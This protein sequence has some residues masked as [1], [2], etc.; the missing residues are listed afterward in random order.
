MLSQLAAVAPSIG[1][2][3]MLLYTRERASCQRHFIFLQTILLIT[4]RRKRM[5]F[6]R[7]FDSLVI[8]NLARFTT[9]S[10]A[11]SD[12]HRSMTHSSEYPMNSS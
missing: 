6:I 2:S 11:Q 1:Q 5:L 4:E 9:G 3:F 12:H 8:D 7:L 10:S